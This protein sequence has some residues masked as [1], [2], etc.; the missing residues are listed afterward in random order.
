VFN[1]ALGS[2]EE[3]KEFKVI[4]TGNQTVFSSFLRPKEGL[5]KELV[6]LV[7]VR[8]LDDVIEKLAP[9]I[10]QLRSFLKCDTQGFDIEVVKG[11]GAYMDQILGLQSEISVIPIY[12]GMPHFTDALNYYES[13]GFSLFD[14]SVVNTTQDGAVLEYDCLMAKRV[15]LHAVLKNLA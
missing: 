9:E 8:R 5:K 15:E 10:K 3:K 13:L 11:T 6:R 2:S 14:L 12:E 7:E 4:V 1:F